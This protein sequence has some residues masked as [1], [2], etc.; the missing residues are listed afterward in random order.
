MNN[1]N[2]THERV[3]TSM[4][5]SSLA[6]Q[7]FHDGCG[8]VWINRGLTLH[9]LDL[10]VDKGLVEKSLMGTMPVYKLIESKPMD[11]HDIEGNSN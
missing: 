8:W 4:V 5:L 11:N 2:L 10:L 3:N 1:N 7:P 6:S 9:I